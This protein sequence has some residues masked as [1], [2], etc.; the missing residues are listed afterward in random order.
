MREE[1]SPL[2]S[3]GKKSAE[4]ALRKRNVGETA[5]T[6]ALNELHGLHE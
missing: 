6:Y 5:R 4:T 2:F 3:Q 1:S